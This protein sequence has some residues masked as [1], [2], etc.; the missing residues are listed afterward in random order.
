MTSR[1]ASP[2]LTERFD[3]A[4]TLAS[5]LHRHQVRKGTDVPYLSHLMAVAALVLEDG[6]GEDMAVAALLHDAVEDQ[7]GQPTVDLIQRRFGRDVTA[8]VEA[9]SEGAD[10]SELQWLTRKRRQ[11]DRLVSAPPQ[12]LRIKAADTLHN[13][14][15]LLTDWED[16]GQRVWDRFNAGSC[17]VNQLWH[18]G[19]L[20]RIVRRVEGESRLPHR[21]DAALQQLRERPHPPCHMDHEHPAPS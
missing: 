18:Y 17:A 20:A 4:L 19:E 15:G 1:V 10:R 13:V 3:E 8:I 11:L 21:L 14:L 5:R 2:K 6:G 16:C 7:G 9:L 12:V